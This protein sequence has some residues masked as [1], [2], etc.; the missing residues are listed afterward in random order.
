MKKRVIDA[1]AVIKYGVYFLIMFLL[2]LSGIGEDINPFYL[3]F[4]VAL[5][6]SGENALILA[7]LYVVALLI[8][9]FSLKSFIA[10]VIPAVIFTLADFLHRRFKRRMTLLLA[11]VYA[12]IASLPLLIFGIGNIEALIDAVVTIIISQV[13]TYA[14]IVVV[15][16][17]V[18]KRLRYRL[19]VD[20]KAMGV[21]LLMSISLGLYNIDIFGFKIF[22]VV[23]SFATLFASA[24]LSPITA[25]VV[26]FAIGAGGGLGSANLAL[27]GAMVLECL[28]AAVFIRYNKYFSAVSVVIIDIMC[29]L[30]FDVFP[31]YGYLHVIAV[32]L[33]AALFLLVRKKH[34]IYLRNIYNGKNSKTALK[35]MINRNRI[36]VNSRIVN[37]AG[38]F[39]EIGIEMKKSEVIL[40]DRKGREEAAER[41]VMKL[42]SSCPKKEECFLALGS[43]TSAVFLPLIDTVIDRGRA[44]I[45]D[46][47]TFLTSRCVKVAELLSTVNEFGEKYVNSRIHTANVL[48]MKYAIGNEMESVGDVL[49][50]LSSS[51]SLKVSADEEMEE[52]IIEELNI[53][54]IVCHDV[55]VMHNGMGESEI[56]LVIRNSD[57]SRKI[58]KSILEKLTRQRLVARADRQSEIKGFATI[59]YV[60]A[61]KYNLLYGIA[62]VKKDGS[63]ASGDTKSVE[64][65]DGDKVIAVLSDGMGSGSVAEANSVN[66]INVIE[67]FY[68]AGFDSETILPLAN[69]L[70]S[71][72][73]SDNFSALD[74]C[75]IDLKSGGSDFIKLGGVSSYVKRK[76]KVE[77]IS[78]SSLPIGVLDEAEPNTVKKVLGDGDIV[79]ITSDGVSDAIDENAMMSMLLNMRGLNPQTIAEDILI[80]ATK[81]G[82]KDDSTVIALRL[83]MERV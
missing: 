81:N 26:A 12:L 76:N 11:N 8:G 9:D 49:G 35:A 10:G 57:A 66:T 46:L 45:V 77:I 28:T 62:G 50:K 41:V 74:M 44:S 21:V 80:E 43:D 65:I 39:K 27:G 14:S 72:R 37:L 63:D 47:T 24:T 17:V 40:K 1:R 16:A 7:P 58:V 20:E 75:V 32:V 36:D 78:T 6:F 23:S 33:G 25:T 2:G 30:Y 82:A 70:L 3:G 18:V 67:K 51:V 79:I 54:G 61:P 48:D 52:R 34:I 38:I 15:F 73:N 60:A 13:F 53:M 64:R 71:M 83:V 42:C 69:K 31:T 68:K 22:Y 29:G 5:V 19:S 56:T 59:R 55:F 4:F